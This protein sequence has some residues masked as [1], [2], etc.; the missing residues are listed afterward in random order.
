ME[1]KAGLRGKKEL[2]VG[3]GDLASSSGNTGAD[4]LSTSRIILLMEHAARNAIEGCLPEGK[5]TV[6]T[7]IDM[8]HFAA[9]PEGMKVY[10][11]AVLKTVEGPRMV[12]EVVVYD[13]YEKISEGMNERYVVSVEK[14]RRR[15]ERKIVMKNK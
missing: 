12:F 1:L 11:E 13:E 4:V 9:T 6:G 7:R 2:T 8:R 10:A 14:F 5:I 3:V 15:L